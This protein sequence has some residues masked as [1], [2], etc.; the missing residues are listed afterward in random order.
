ML[1]VDRDITSTTFVFIIS[2]P[3]KAKNKGSVQKKQKKKTDKELVNPGPLATLSFPSIFWK[4]GIKDYRSQS[5][6]PGINVLVLILRPTGLLHTV[7][8]IVVT[9][10]C[11]FC[12]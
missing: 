12:Q 7:I 5:R 6:D 10:R 9:H 4:P 1:S 3:G 11:V 8:V 2:F